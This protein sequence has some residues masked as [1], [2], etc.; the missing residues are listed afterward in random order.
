VQTREAASIVPTFATATDASRKARLIVNV[1]DTAAREALRIEASGTAPMIGFLG[2]AAVVRAAHIADPS[3]GA[4]QDAEAR[5]AINAIL[6]VIENLGFN[7]T[8]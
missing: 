2:A 1:Y 6:V 3:G 7:A 4:I 5:T 8:S